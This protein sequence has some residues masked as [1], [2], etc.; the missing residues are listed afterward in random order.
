[1]RLKR[2]SEW[3]KENIMSASEKIQLAETERGI[4][5]QVE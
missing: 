2:K 5:W 3:D 1:M 4:L